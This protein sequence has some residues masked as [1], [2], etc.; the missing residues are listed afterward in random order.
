MGR[1]TILN[2]YSLFPTPP[3]PLT[4]SSDCGTIAAIE[5]KQLRGNNP[6]GREP[7]GSEGLNWGKSGQRP[8]QST[9]L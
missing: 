7:G 1:L 6:A 8:A 4:H 5:Y 2:P 9:L 3:S